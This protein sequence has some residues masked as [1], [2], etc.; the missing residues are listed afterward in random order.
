MN[1]TWALFLTCCIPSKE[2][3]KK[4]RRRWITR[5]TPELFADLS[6]RIARQQDIS[7]ETLRVIRSTAEKCEALCDRIPDL[8]AGIKETLDVGREMSLR[9]EDISTELRSRKAETQALQHALTQT[10][11]TDFRKIQNTVETC[12]KK[13]EYIIQQNAAQKVALLSQYYMH[14]PIREKLILCFD[15]LYDKYAEAVD[16]YTMFRYLKSAGRKVKYVL[17][18]TNPLYERLQE[19]N[20]L[21][22]V[23]PV[24]N[25]AEMLILYP[26]I[27]AQS[28]YIFCSFGYYY[29]KILKQL[30]SCIYIYI[31]HGVMLLKKSAFALY[32]DGGPCDNDLM[33]V[34]T[35]ATKRYYDNNNY[36]Q[37]Q[38]LC[39]GMPRW[40]NLPPRLEKKEKTY[41]IF[42]FFT[43]RFSFVRD[44]SQVEHYTSLIQQTVN[45]LAD[46]LKDYE[47]IKIYLG[48]HH[49][50]I[51]NQ[52]DKNFDHFQNVELV[53]PNQV[54]SMVKKA[55][56]LVTDYSSI[57]FDFMYQD[58]P[59]IFYRFDA[60]VTYS[61]ERDNKAIESAAQEDS[62]LYNICSNLDEVVK[63]V[64]EYAESDFKAGEEIILKNKAIFW[65]RGNNC[66]RLLKLVDEYAA[67][68]CALKPL[69]EC[70]K[71]NGE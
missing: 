37:H 42:L 58:V 6:A 11:E 36:K 56:L 3:R 13:I 70:L 68:E 47:H 8:Q 27:I 49:A 7:D 41:S 14:I 57:C 30:P 20:Q 59:V 18:K 55:D 45:E 39:A 62:I 52:P 16:A 50:L 53:P 34:P 29:S 38:M 15:C 48:L 67:G 26:D 46:R 60:D 61:D 22:D 44:S 2:L 25:E 63:K 1:K 65:P 71:V 10:M 51:Y 28:G 9:S 24:S 43:W 23:L 12:R 4:L 64:L 21:E 31:D 40:D 35:Q 5:S 32:A 17:L 54:S 66:E 19:Q 69:Y 33:L